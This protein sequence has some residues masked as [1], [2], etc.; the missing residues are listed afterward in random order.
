MN[1]YE[2][3]IER[4]EMSEPVDVKNEMILLPVILAMTPMDR[5]ILTEAYAKGQCTGDELGKFNTPATGNVLGFLSRM[6]SLT[7]V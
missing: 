3:V 4:N 7:L 2:I 1:E 5:A 6:A